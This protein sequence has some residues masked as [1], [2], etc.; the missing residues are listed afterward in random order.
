MSQ[1]PAKARFIIIQLVRLSG[2][3]M[4]VFGLLIMARRIDLPVL[5]GYL[6][7]AV[8]LFEAVIAPLLLARRW[9]SPT[10]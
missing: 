7:A 9:K 5:A 6:I 8:G 4:V 3:A 10:E 1:D 2:V